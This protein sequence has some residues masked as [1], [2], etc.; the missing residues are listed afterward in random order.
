MLTA[1]SYINSDLLGSFI[2]AYRSP[3]E[4]KR[5]FVDNFSVVMAEIEN[6]KSWQQNIEK[7]HQALVEDVIGR[8]QKAMKP[9]RWVR[10]DP[11]PWFYMHHY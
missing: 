10:S 9:D 4:G 5:Q 1:K 6:R 3:S 2:G 11:C 8:I 7:Q